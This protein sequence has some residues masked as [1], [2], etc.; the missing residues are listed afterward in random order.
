VPTTTR[1]L[2]LFLRSTACVVVCLVKKEADLQC[3]VFGWCVCV[4]VCVIAVFGLHGAG[5]YYIVVILEGNME[6]G[7]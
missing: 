6:W 1:T 4:C 5:P 2:S 7:G 3:G